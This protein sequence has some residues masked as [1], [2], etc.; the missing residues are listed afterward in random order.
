MVR[1][2]Q[3]QP[4]SF[5]ISG[6]MRSF[7]LPA[8]PGGSDGGVQPRSA[9]QEFLDIARKSPLERMR[10]K[11]MEDMKLSQDSLA[12]LTPDQRQ[13]VEDEIKRRMMEALQAA[14]EPGQ[15]IDKEA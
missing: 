14:T 1:V 5:S 9:E 15:V 11:I 8:Q 10:D 3:G 7:L 12:S 6:S 4:M 2:N 13:S